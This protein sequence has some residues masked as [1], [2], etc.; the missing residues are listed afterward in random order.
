MR[1]SD[2][3]ICEGCGYSANREGMQ[4]RGMRVLQICH[5]LRFFRNVCEKLPVLFSLKILYHLKNK[6][7]Y[8][9]LELY[10][11]CAHGSLTVVE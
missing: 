5:I 4:I 11:L 1:A 10:Q 8:I 9:F 2:N 3:V 7:K 6:T